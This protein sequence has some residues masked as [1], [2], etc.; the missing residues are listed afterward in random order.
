M[1]ERLKMRK[2]LL[3]LA[4]SALIAAGCSSHQ[5]IPSSGHSGISPQVRQSGEHPVQWRRFHW[6]SVQGPYY[7]TIVKGPDGNMWYTD[8]SGAEL[9]RMSMSGAVQRFPLTS[10]N[11]TS[12]TVGSDGKFYSGSPSLAAIDVTTTAG[13]VSQKAIPSGDVVAY[14]GMSLGPDHNV[15]FAENKHVA[16]IT[17]AGVVT[18]YVYTS[19]ATGN[20]IGSTTAGPDG[21]VWVTDYANSQVTQVIPSTGVQKSFALGCNPTSIVSAKGSLYIDCSPQSDLA[22][23]TPS[24]STATVTLLKNAFGFTA[25]GEALAVGPDGNPWFVTSQ[26][27]MI[28]EYD[29]GL[30]QMSFF[31]PPAN[32]GTDDSLTLGPDGNMWAVDVSHTIDVYI[33]NIMSVS[34]ASLTFTTHGTTQNITVTQNGTTAWTAKSTNT[35]VVTVAQGSPA[36]VF[37]VTSV[38]KGTAKIIVSDAV[39]NSFAVLVTVQ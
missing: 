12:L 11:P 5:A 34:P 2:R 25:T 26:G 8:Y 38:A 29:P 3:V 19:G 13:A 23:V 22:Q 16:N 30:G 4:F 20:N 1:Q 27:G 15:W 32:Y 35:A 28:G 37:K 18:E 6:G 10:F 33:L 21:N 9:V 17:P 39:G 36:S 24:G 7:P 31:Y 14:A